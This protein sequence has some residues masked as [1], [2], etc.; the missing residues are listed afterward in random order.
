VDLEQF[1]SKIKIKKYILHKDILNF[2]NKLELQLER[3]DTNQSI[4]R[5]IIESKEINSEEL[6]ELMKSIK[7]IDN[8]L[9]SL[10]TMIEKN[11]KYF[12]LLKDLKENL[13]VIFITVDYIYDLESWGLTVLDGITRKF[14][15]LE[16]ENLTYTIQLLEKMIIFESKNDNNGSISYFAKEIL[17]FCKVLGSL[18]REFLP[19]VVLWKLPPKLIQLYNSAKKIREK[20]NIVSDIVNSDYYSEKLSNAINNSEKLKNKLNKTS[21]IK[22]RGV[23]GVKRD[24]WSIEMLEMAIRHVIRKL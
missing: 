21:P 10:K 2:I 23:A 17:Y 9:K 4:L 12:Q 13:K 20:I 5:E 7:G 18:N 1:I 14:Y 6:L 8:V 11:S 24:A 16:Y 15:V 3:L 19:Y 22:I